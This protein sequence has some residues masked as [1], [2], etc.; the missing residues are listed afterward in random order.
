MKIGIAGSGMIV[1]YVLENVWNEVGNIE[2]KAIWC[3]DAERDAAE[4][5]A[6]D[7]S[8]KDIYEDYD[9]F[10]KDNSFDFVYIGLVNSLHYEYSLK[11]IKAGKSV[12]C[13]KPFTSTAKQAKELLD[14]ARENHVYVFESILPWYSDNYDE[15]KNRLPEVGDIKLIQCNF[16]QYSRRYAS[17]LNG[18][19]LPVFNPLLDGGALYDIGVYSIHWVMG[20]A[21]VPEKTAYFPN[22]G[23]NGIDTSGI[24]VMDYGSFKAVC[25]SAKDSAS[26]GCC[27]VQGDKGCIVMHSHPG[28]C[29]KI[30]LTLNGADPVCLDKAPL[31]EPF[32]NVYERILPIVEKDEY[33]VCYAM[34]D[35]VI[36]VMQVMEDARK[37]AGIKFSCD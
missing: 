2:A 34:M 10:L 7:Y 11:A 19:V 31:G 22:I 21:G 9:E 26:P 13:E 25:T 32:V 5:I 3:R 15:I 1:R 30:E 18:T 17:Y 33:D 35:K 23:Y 27:M 37:G 28:E 36:E 20:L 24:L 14:A 12:I 29:H 8:I 16:S 6:G 4:N